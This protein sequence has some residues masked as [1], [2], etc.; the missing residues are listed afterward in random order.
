MFQRITN[1]YMNENVLNNLFTNRNLLIDLQRQIASGKR[2]ER[3]SDDVLSSTIILSSNSALGKIENYLKNIETAK[4]EIEIA[5][6]A[7]LKSL[8]SVHESRE[9]VIKALNATSGEEELGI[10]ASRLE[11]IIQQVKDLG[12][13]KYGNKFVFGGKETS[14]VPFTE[15]VA[16]E[17]QYNGSVS[18]S[19]E[20]EIEIAEGVQVAV[21][22]CGDDIFGHYYYWDHDADILT[23]DVLSRNGLLGTLSALVVEMR[24]TPPDKEVI[25]QELDNL[26]TDLATLLSSQSSLGGLLTRIEVTERIHEDDKI[27]LSDKKANAEGIDYAQAISDLKF[28]ESALQ[29]SLQ[30]SAQIIKPSLLNYI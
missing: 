28:Q 29:A 13:T 5:D 3:A 19:H 1:G 11:Q 15:P 21:N 14:T 20:R 23:P 22:M 18:G 25:R 24:N 16:G 2:L 12:N 30:V 27:T 6:G 10:I 26:D 9:L 4:S 8:D 17:I 7:I